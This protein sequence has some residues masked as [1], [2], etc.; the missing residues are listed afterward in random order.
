[1]KG[2]PY[3]EI[4]IV[5]WFTDPPWWL[6]A[7]GKIYFKVI[8][9]VL[10]TASRAAQLTSWKVPLVSLD[11]AASST[12]IRLE[13]VSQ[14]TLRPLDRRWKRAAALQQLYRCSTRS[15]KLDPWVTV[16]CPFLGQ[17]LELPSC[18]LHSRLCHHHSWTRSLFCQQSTVAHDLDLHLLLLP[19]LLVVSPNHSITAHGWLQFWSLIKQS[20]A[21]RIGLNFLAYNY[22]QTGSYSVLIV[23]GQESCKS[24]FF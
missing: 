19:L 17:R 7:K 16:V 3:L 23:Q 9:I 4:R 8:Y 22:A 12:C 1:M 14:R 10:W 15:N 11:S 2:K 13:K 21:Y 20:S 5:A 6:F 18:V 24:I